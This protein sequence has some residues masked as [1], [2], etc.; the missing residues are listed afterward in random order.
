MQVCLRC[1][2]HFKA[3]GSGDVRVRVTQLV[4]SALLVLHQILLNPYAAPLAK[5]QLE[6]VLISR[7]SQSLDCPD[8]YVQVLLLDVVYA[9]LKLRE[10]LPVE[11]PPSPSTEKRKPGFEAGSQRGSVSADKIPRLPPPPPALL[12]CLQAGLSSPSSRPVLDSWISF[13]TE[14]LPY[15]SDSIFQV[16]IP[17]VGTLCDQVGS[18]FSSL[19]Q[20]FKA[21]DLEW[22]VKL[23]APESTLISFLN[24]LEHVLAKSH[25]RLLLEEARIP[26]AKGQDQPQGFFGNMVS[27]VFSTESLHA[28]SATANDRLTVLLAFQDAVRICFKIWSWGQGRDAAAQNPS[29]FASFNYTSLRM[30]N[31]ARRL[32]EHLFAAE[33]LECLETV[34]DIWKKSLDDSSSSSHVEVFNLLPALDGSRPKHTVPAIFN[35]IY[36]RTN[37]AALDPAR[38][39]NLTVDLQD[40]DIVI[41]LVDYAKSLEDD[42]MDEI[43]QD[44]IAFLRDLLANP[45]PHRQTLPSLLEFAAILGEKVDNTNFGEQRKMRRELG[46]RRIQYRL[47]GNATNNDLQDLFLRLLTALFTTRPVS[48]S[49]NANGTS[50]KPK[51]LE[52]GKQTTRSRNP[53]ERA[54]D[55]VGI[56]S[57]I[58][59][60][61]PKILVENDRVLSAATSISASVIGPALRAKAFPETFT[62][63]ALVMLQELS[64]LPGNQKTWKRDVTDAFNDARFFSSNV[65]L[66]QNDWLPLLRQWTITDKDRMP[67]LLSRITAPTTAGI[68]FGVGATSA[69]LEADRKTQLTLRRIATLVLATAEDT[70][71]TELPSI[72]DKLIELLGATATSSPSSTTRA[73][74]FMVVRALVLKTSAIH[75]AP[76]WPVINAE[77]HAAVSSVASPDH[78][79]ASE[80]YNNLS[81]LQACKLLDVLICVAPDDFQ[82]HE[83]LFV[84]DTIDAVYRPADYQPVALVDE[85]SEELGT[86]MTGPSPLA[87]TAP[88]LAASGSGKRPLLEASATRGDV[89]LDRREDLVT[90]V[91]R[92]F[93]GQLSIFAFESTYAMGQVDLDGCLEA[94]LKD[95]FDEASIVRQL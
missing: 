21:S 75:L 30:R 7:L 37:P 46:V 33:T 95:L 92:P 55:V 36:S 18:T 47:I 78:S 69:R 71:V 45:F 24:G 90:K 32:L 20:M 31:R 23:N 72:L 6:D 79:P 62:K 65:T 68:V 81:V 35:S 53:Q 84:T 44:C 25:D 16:L 51:R 64:R 93:F 94:L 4:R 70:F 85:L 22:V 82:L 3:S 86:V 89:N 5:L 17:L 57:S 11:P 63:G 67:E 14:C 91:L 61:L 10:M 80:T 19:Q 50:E 34:I 48:F 60:N 27:G 66:V 9:S 73:E 76:I 1:I 15:Y 39:S 74:L 43:W 2:S 12:K 49:D 26:V 87:E 41:F 52:L 13:L 28:R 29:S 58:V 42:A 83:W 59:P 40:T 8:P 54:D 77:I 56:L 88:F 38:K